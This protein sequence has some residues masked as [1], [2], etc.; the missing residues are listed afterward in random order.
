LRFYRRSGL[1][2]SVDQDAAIETVAAAAAAA[3]PR[4]DQA[5]IGAK[6]LAALAK[7][8]KRLR[9]ASAHPNRV[10]HH[11]D[12]FT[13]LL[14][15]FF[16]PT[17]RSLRSLDDASQSPRVRDCL[18]V[19]R[20]CRSTLSDANACL[21][22]RL[23]E[24]VI[25]DLR[26]RLPHL[27]RADGQLNQLLARSVANDGS[28]FAVAGHV[29]WAL[30]KRKPHSTRT[31]DRFV[32]LDLQYCCA[33]GV[34]EGLEVNG[35]GT[36]ETTAFR[37]HIEPGKLYI[38][39]RGIFSFAY[40]RDLL[41]AKADLVLRIKTS[42]RL[43]VVRELPLTAQQKAAGV[44][45]DRIVKL[46]PAAKA[47]AARASQAELREVVILDPRNPGK[48]VRLLTNLLDVPAELVGD[49]YR[50]R[51]QIELFFRWL[52][53]HA[54]FRHVISHGANGLT[55]WFYVAV[56]GVLLMY[57]HTGRKM[58]KYAY[59]MLC[60]VAQGGATL[61]DVLPILERRERE[62]DLDRQRLARKR[63]EKTMS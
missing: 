15:G 34:I 62:R 20:A 36:S 42:Q 47:D 4:A 60:L 46:D 28:F 33:R 45:A 49:V 16:N 6:Y 12:L 3:G 19:E 21:D 5:L 8:R 35:K 18:E 22:P 13:L 63:A 39:D 61:A 59:N 51:W 31:D 38:A 2:W 53:V 17:L 37:R 57:L 30:R 25:A 7:H 56:I 11:D 44:L 50:W 27:P 29:A 43:S 26:A 32:R 41:D 10:L 14:L 48:P 23:L 55:T 54:H 9:K 58:S 52:K 24:P 40:V 1:L